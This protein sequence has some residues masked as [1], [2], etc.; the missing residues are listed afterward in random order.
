MNCVVIAQRAA[1]E[2]RHTPTLRDCIVN[3]IATKAIAW[4]VHASGRSG[5][6][7]D[8]LDEYRVFQTVDYMFN[9][10]MFATED[11]L[12]AKLLAT[13]L[14][15][16]GITDSVYLCNRRDEEVV[17]AIDTRF[18]HVSSPLLY[19]DVDIDDYYKAAWLRYTKCK[20]EDAIYYLNLMRDEAY[21]H[22]TEHSGS[23]L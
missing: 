5:T 12:V 17:A 3:K 21:Y 20:R 8:L 10:R 15:E 7:I 9:N 22:A 6:H 19:G 2:G 23:L 11:Y 4:E 16:M 18:L 13:K 1:Q 14:K